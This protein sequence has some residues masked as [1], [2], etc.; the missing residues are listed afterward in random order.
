[1]RLQNLAQDVDLDRVGLI[2]CFFIPALW[3]VQQVQATLFVFLWEV[4]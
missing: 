4:R 1:M 3:Q 2:L